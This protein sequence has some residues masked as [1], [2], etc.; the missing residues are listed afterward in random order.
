MSSGI[1]S[2]SSFFADEGTVAH[3]VADQVL[4]SASLTAADFIGQTLRGQE[5]DVEVTEEMADAVEVYVQTVRTDKMLLKG[6]LT[7][8]QK[9]DLSVLAK[10]IHLPDGSTPQLYGRNDA[11]L[12]VEED[13]TLI[14]YDYKHGKGHAVDV[15]HNPQLLY[16]GLGGVL[17]RDRMKSNRVKQIELVVV[18]PRAPHADGPVR[19]WQVSMADLLDWT[20]DLLQ[21]VERTTEPDAP[22]VV[23]DHCLFCPAMAICPAQHK[24]AQQVASL[25]FADVAA[26]P[27]AVESLTLNQIVQVLNKSALVEDFIRAVQQHA[28]HLAETGTTI[29]GWKIVQ[30]RPRRVY[31][32][33]PDVVAR[34]VA[35]LGLDNE[36]IYTEPEVKSVA[37]LETALKRAGCLTEEIGR[38]A[39]RGVWE[40]QSSGTTLTPENDPRTALPPSVQSDFADLSA[41]PDPMN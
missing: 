21:A 26:L 9:F 7:V 16:Y 18:Q 11:S 36:A 4:N 13:G 29:P 27:P 12:F 17:Q 32:E 23:G 39:W 6:R 33:R 20:G 35:V 40:K 31:T 41:V 15:E 24:L 30:K 37:Q 10:G 8:E 2:R 22:L 3:S 19:R 5:H 34:T 38:Q 14:I 1:Q 25:E 28:H